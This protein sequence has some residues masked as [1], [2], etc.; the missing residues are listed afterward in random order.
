MTDLKGRFVGIFLE[1]GLSQAW[2]EICYRNRRESLQD[3]EVQEFDRV[4]MQ[5]AEDWERYSEL[6][7]K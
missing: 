3:L 4:V 6:G 7:N 1:F 2:A 5:S